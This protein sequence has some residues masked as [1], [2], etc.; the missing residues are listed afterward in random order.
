MADN[1]D[2][3]VSEIY[4]NN[5]QANDAIAEM[6]KQLTKLTD[7]YDD[8]AAK[9]E[10]LA[11]KTNKAKAAMEE[12][13]KALE[14]MKE[15]TEEYAK[16]SKKLK[17]QEKAYNDLAKKL[18][19]SKHKT[20]QAKRE[21]DSMQESIKRADDGV[22]KFGKAMENL[23]GKSME[24][25]VRMQRQLRSEL[26]KTKPNTK[27]W[28]ELAKKYQ[29]VT[30]EMKRLEAV[31]SGVVIKQQGWLQR[32]NGVSSAFLFLGQAARTAIALAR[33]F[34]DAYVLDERGLRGIKEKKADFIN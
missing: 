2:T 4:V 7:K 11:A 9:N 29:Q 27:E 23:T 10:K 5:E 3:F 33:R 13:A 25:L 12:T 15:G 24:N 1:R 30:A 20:D 22:K 19:I 6:T 18:E 14:G 21:M 34:A 17:E 16:T 8:L 31:Q 32:L 28:D 26:D